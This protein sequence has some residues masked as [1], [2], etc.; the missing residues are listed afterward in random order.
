MLATHAPRKATNKNK[1]APRLQRNAWAFSQTMHEHRDSYGREK[2]QLA[3]PLAR[4]PGSV[5]TNCIPIR[6]KLP[7]NCVMNVPNNAR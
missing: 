2:K 4:A 1:S 7:V 3:N 6:T 5:L